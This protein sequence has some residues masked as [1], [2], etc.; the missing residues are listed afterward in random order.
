MTNEELKASLREQMRE[1][2]ESV[3]I[4]DAQTKVTMDMVKLGIIT[5]EEATKNVENALV[6]VKA[7][8]ER[9]VSLRQWWERL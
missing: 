8:K 4:L 9:H 6:E 1:A 3:M 2:Y 7:L 5:K